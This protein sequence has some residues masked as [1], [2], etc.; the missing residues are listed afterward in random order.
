M[1]LVDDDPFVSSFDLK[2]SGLT[3]LGRKGD[4]VSCR[5]TGAALRS[6]AVR[7]HTVGARRVARGTVSVR[8]T[9]RNPLIVRV[10]R[11]RFGQRLLA[12]RLGG[13]RVVVTARGLATNGQRVKA[14]A[15]TRAI[16]NP[17]RFVTPAATWV[18]DRAILTPRG[19]RFMK[20]LRG[21]IRAVHGFTCFGHTA[22]IPGD[23]GPAI[24]LSRAR[25][26]VMCA[27]LR[28]LGA[29]GPVRLVAR[30]NSRPIATNATEAGRRQ[31]RRVA[32]K[33]RH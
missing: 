27:R 5:L 18:P 14:R 2:T 7:V 3:V 13:V 32:V 29:R 30:G 21:K 31:N 17:E 26:R 33:L 9:G 15:R 16:L 19:Q 4:T 1:A 22:R 23:A 10:R 12:R 8:S 28:H 11:T 25:A 6:C 20:R 24:P